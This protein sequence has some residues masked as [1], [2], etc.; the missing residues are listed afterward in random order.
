VCLQYYKPEETKYGYDKYGKKDDYNKYE[1]DSYNK[2]EVSQNP[3]TQTGCT[4]SLDLCAQELCRNRGS[5]DRPEAGLCCLVRC[6]TPL[7]WHCFDCS[8]SSPSRTSAWSGSDA[9]ACSCCC[10]QD[11]YEKKDTYNKYT[12]Y[13]E[14]AAATEVSLLLPA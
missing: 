8:K 1:K 11:K 4:H 5:A 13:N 9:T 3:K 10:L 2:Y 12:K 6:M 14:K 7:P